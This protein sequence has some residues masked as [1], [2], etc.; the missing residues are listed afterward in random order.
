MNRPG[1]PPCAHEAPTRVA[2]S[3]S[4][5]TAVRDRRWQSAKPGCRRR[6]EAV[7]TD[8]HVERSVPVP[9]TTSPPPRAEQ[10]QGFAA[11]L[12]QSIGHQGQAGGKDAGL[13][14][15]PLVGGAGQG[16][17]PEVLGR[18]ET[19]Q[20]RGGHRR[21]HQPS[22]AGHPGRGGQAPPG[23]VQ[24]HQLPERVEGIVE[25]AHGQRGPCGGAGHG[26]AG[27]W[28]RRSH[29]DRGF[30]SRLCYSRR[31]IR[32]ARRA[33]AHGGRR[34]P[35]SGHADRAADQPRRD[36]HE[37]SDVADLGSELADERGPFGTP[38]TGVGVEDHP[39][40]ALLVDH[41][42]DVAVGHHATGRRHLG[43]DPVVVPHL[44]SWASDPVR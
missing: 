27:Q 13:P 32:P 2:P 31:R 6:A 5:L 1:R 44:W 41:V 40:P 42:D 33:E 38:V 39:G 20:D 19:G 8:V 21:D 15:R 16:R 18:P 17:E 3:A 30:A 22:V 14:T 37:W 4:R 43:L 10:G 24:G 9:A 36:R 28:D 34:R 26:G 35:A 23:A 11:T 29:R 25:V 12:G 7:V